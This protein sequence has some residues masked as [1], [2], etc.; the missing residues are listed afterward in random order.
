MAPEG[1]PAG[2]FLLLGPTGTGKT[3]TVEALAD[4]VHDAL[5]LQTAH[6]VVPVVVLELAVDQVRGTSL[7]A[8]AQVPISLRV[9]NERE[10]VLRVGDRDPA[11]SESVHGPSTS[12]GS[13]TAI[14][15]GSST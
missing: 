11:S 14:R 1:R 8:H 2:V 3:R 10:V 13:P 9:E 7:Q 5:D 6:L 12:K 15:P 4:A